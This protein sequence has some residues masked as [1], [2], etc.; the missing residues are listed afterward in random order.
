MSWQVKISSRTGDQYVTNNMLGLSMWTKR[1][2]LKNHAILLKNEQ[3]YYT[4]HMVNYNSIKRILF[5]CES[6][7]SNWVIFW[8]DQTNRPYIWHNQTK[9]K[10][11]L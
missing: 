11:W 9:Q 3:Q 2:I 8:H 10:I 7:F 1:K 4:T 6:D 5:P